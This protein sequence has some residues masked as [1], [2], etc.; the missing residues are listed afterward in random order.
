ME[1]PV[2]DEM[3]AK[4]ESATAYALKKPTELDHA[5]VE[6]PRGKVMTSFDLLGAKG[7][8]ADWA[9]RALAGSKEAL[10]VCHNG[11][12]LFLF[13]MHDD[14]TDRPVLDSR[15][16]HAV[17]EAG[18]KLFKWRSRWEIEEAEARANG[19]NPV[20]KL[21]HWFDLVTEL[22]LTDVLPQLIFFDPRP[23]QG[24]NVAHTKELIEAKLDPNN[25]RRKALLEKMAEFEGR[26][27]AK[28]EI[29]QGITVEEV[30]AKLEAT[31]AE[32]EEAKRLAALR[33][34]KQRKLATQ[35]TKLKQ[36]IEKAPG[37]GE[38]E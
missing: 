29:E 11:L 20:P 18:E 13:L 17:N 3:K 15:G 21:T 1:A 32:L 23:Q 36:K 14:C 7:D 9:R 25:P 24:R 6:L 34:E 28:V 19:D 8:P 5:L 10:A 33:L 30:M 35:N 2:I 37:E 38:Q 26:Q 12:K 27:E 16:R 4:R 31:K 22:W